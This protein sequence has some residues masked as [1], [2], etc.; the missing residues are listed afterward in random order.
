MTTSD[1][2]AVGRDVS[3]EEYEALRRALTMISGKWK[4]EILWLLYH[5]THRFGEL[6]KTIRGVSQHV[7]TKQL[8]ELEADGLITRKVYAEVPPRVE[9]SMTDATRE[10]EATIQ[11]LMHW[12]ENHGINTRGK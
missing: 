6:Q 4:L 9:Y 12:W 3:P 8:R 7:L 5:R 10:L 11:S 2:N 1:A